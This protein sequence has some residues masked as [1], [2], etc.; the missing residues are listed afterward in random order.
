MDLFGGAEGKDEVKTKVHVRAR[1]D[2]VERLYHR[3]QEQESLSVGK[4]QAIFDTLVHMAEKNEEAATAEEKKRVWKKDEEGEEEE[5]KKKGEE[6]GGGRA[7][8]RTALLTSIG[9]KY[10]GTGSV[11]KAGV[12]PVPVLKPEVE[13]AALRGVIRDVQQILGDDRLQEEHF[14][15]GAITVGDRETVDYAARACCNLLQGVSL[16]RTPNSMFW[17]SQLWGRYKEYSYDA[18]Y[19]LVV[20]MLANM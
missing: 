19:E 10:F 12:K 8:A 16:A 13:D 6:E 14:G 4:T 17:N 2:V 18:L 15:H 20:G 1:Q 7:E 5:E 11:E 3:M 9:T